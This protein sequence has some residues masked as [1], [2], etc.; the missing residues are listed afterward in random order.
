MV[1][2]LGEGDVGLVTWLYVGEPAHPGLWSNL[3]TLFI[4]HGFLPSVLV[5]Q[6]T[7]GRQDCFGASAA[8]R[9]SG[10]EQ[11]GGF[12][13]L[14]NRLAD[15]HALG[16]AGPGLGPRLPLAPPLWTD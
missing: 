4:N 10:L 16:Q 7:G 1:G 11:I 3:G 13:A 6:L 12:P 8:L 15:D 2:G 9:R 5:G 14:R